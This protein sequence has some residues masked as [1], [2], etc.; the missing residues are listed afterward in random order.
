MIDDLDSYPAALTQDSAMPKLVPF[1][2]KLEAVVAKPF[3]FDLAANHVQYPDSLTLRAEDRSSG[4]FSKF[5]GF[6]KS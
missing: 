4:L 6:G 5:F 1:P 3:Y 2:P